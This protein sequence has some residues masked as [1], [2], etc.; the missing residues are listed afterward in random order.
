MTRRLIALATVALAGCATYESVVVNYDD[1]PSAAVLTKDKGP[2]VTVGFMQSSN[3][4]PS[5]KANR[6]LADER[7]SLRCGKEGLKAEFLSA[8]ETSS[9]FDSWATKKMVASIDNFFYA[10]VQ[11]SE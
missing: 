9:E 3:S 7:A 11:P 2:L 6:A 1:G 8:S 10:C 4:L 5:A